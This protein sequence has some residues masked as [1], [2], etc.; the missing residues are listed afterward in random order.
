LISATCPKNEPEK[1]GLGRTGAV[2]VARAA[3]SI[4]TVG[5]HAAALSVEAK[6]IRVAAAIVAL[7]FVHVCTKID[8]GKQ[9]QAMCAPLT[10]AGSGSGARITGRTGGADPA[11]RE[12]RADSQDVTAAV[13]VGAFINIWQNM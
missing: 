9:N 1:Q 8:V 2:S 13:I 6:D 11:A 7:A 12:I 5:A 3:E 10:N 4:R